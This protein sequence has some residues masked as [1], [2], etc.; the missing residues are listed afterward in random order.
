[1]DLVR[2]LI[3][4]GRYVR[5]ETKIKVRQPISECLIDGK[6]ESILGDLKEL[7][8]EELNV[9]NIVFVE[10]L[11]EYMNF[12]IK[13]NFKVCGAMFGPKMKDYQTLLADLNDEDKEMLVKEQTITVDFD[14]ERLDITPNMVDVRIDAKEG[15]NVGMENNK[16]IILN[17]EL[18]R[19]LILEGLAREVVSKVQ[20]IRKEMDLNIVDRIDIDYSADDEIIDAINSFKEYIMNETLCVNLNVNENIDTIVDINGHDVKLDIKVAK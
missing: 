6:Y 16:F 12:T 14:G 11:S 18:T 5:E 4:T 1:M 20:N 7:I 17:T 13:P 2:D 10:D 8:K 15:F 3:S 9:K 19:E